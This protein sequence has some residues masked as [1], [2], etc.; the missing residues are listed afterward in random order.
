MSNITTEP[1]QRELNKSREVDSRDELC[2]FLE[3]LGFDKMPPERRLEIIEHASLED[4]IYGTAALH[5]K[6]AP[7]A[8]AYPL[9]RPIRL[10]NKTTGS[11]KD[12]AMPEERLPIFEKAHDLTMKV[13]AK[14]RKEGGSLQNVLNRCANLSAFGIVLA[15]PFEDGNGRTAR[16][17]AELIRGGYDRD[18]DFTNSPDSMLM[19]V[20]ANRPEDGVRV[21]AYVPKREGTNDNPEDFLEFVAGLDV[22]F[23]QD[24]YVEAVHKG[25]FTTPYV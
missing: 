23:D 6:L 10:E 11:G 24:Q 5:Q 4:Y 2:D 7:E 22:P 16:T 20:A 19:L 17:M 1:S 25:N 14:Y 15:H 18:R 21:N 13:V 12:L 8:P 3:E 9:D